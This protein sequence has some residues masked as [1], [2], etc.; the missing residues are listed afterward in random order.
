MFHKIDTQT[1][2]H[3]CNFWKNCFMKTCK[4]NRNIIF[5]AV[6]FIYYCNIMYVMCTIRKYCKFM[7]AKSLRN[8]W[9]KVLWK[10]EYIWYVQYG[11]YI[12][13]GVLCAPYKGWTHLWQQ[14]HHPCSIGGHGSASTT[15]G[16]G[17]LHMVNVWIRVF[18][19]WQHG[20]V[21]G[22]LGCN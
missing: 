8:L 15:G 18:C 5:I 1:A 13:L 7:N 16:L 17:F 19:V 14:R 20:Q 4:F 21:I 3:N 11:S 2:I 9:N 6:H 22:C 12:A 10:L